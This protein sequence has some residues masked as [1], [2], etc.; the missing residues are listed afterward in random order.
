MIKELQ[1][2][3]EILVRELKDLKNK[4]PGHKEIL[5]LQESR[6]KDFYTQNLPI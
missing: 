5:Q 4:E 6:I 3:T 2:H 1:N